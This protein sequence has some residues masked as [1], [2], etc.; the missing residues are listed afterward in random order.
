MIFVTGATGFLGSH[1]LHDLVVL[2]RPV[3]ALYRNKEKLDFVRRIF[4]YYHADAERLMNRIDWVQGD[5]LDYYNLA[6]CMKGI[7]QVY[8]CA[9]VVSF[10]YKDKR[11]LFDINVRGTANVVN[12]CLAQS[13]IRLCHVSS[14]AALG[15]SQDGNPVDESNL[16]NHG[17]AVSPYAFSKFRGEMEVWRGIFEGLNAVIVNPSVIIG[18]GIWFGSGSDLFRQIRKGL[19]YYPAGT[20]GFVDV[21]D[22]VH[23]M[24]TLTDSEIR[25]ERFIIS[26]ENKTH[27]EIINC[28]AESMH[29]PIPVR[30]LT[31]IQISLIC[32]FEKLRS[33]LTG[34]PPRVSKSSMQSANAITAY[35]NRKLMNAISV[36]FIPIKE[37]VTF[38]SRMI[39]FF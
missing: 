12:A 31:P 17:S 38:S 9:G 18:P 4:S 5:I 20:S 15:D 39:E 14:I 29:Q 32:Q 35:S 13:G 37:S 10:N 30:P 16:W 3:R 36:N 34:K 6:E 11:K 25:Q 33:L 2:E 19:K 27:R 8:H 7:N 1:L 28:I 21:R 26:A 22:V 23:V 24:I